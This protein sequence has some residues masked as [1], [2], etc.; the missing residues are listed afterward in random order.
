M[1]DAAPARRKHRVQGIIQL[2]LFNIP[3]QEKAVGASEPKQHAKTLW[4]WLNLLGVLAI[5]V[6]V[7][8]GVAWYT[9]QQ[10]KVSKREKTANQREI[11]LQAYIDKMSELLLE[12]GL[13]KS[14]PKD[15]VRT[16][17]R[18][19]TIT[20]LFQLDAR[21]IGYVFTFLQ[22]AGWMSSE[23]DSNIVS[24]RGADLSRANLSGADL[25]G[26]DLAMGNFKGGEPGIVN[27]SGAN[28][29]GAI[30]GVLTLDGAPNLEGITGLSPSKLLSNAMHKGSTHP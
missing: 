9:A 25:S 28:L 5:P 12:T 11:A 26:A 7:G 22:E 18:M 23:A 6:I 24:L 27:L 2:L 13:G 30:P 15:E 14:S 17:A 3:A 21:R 1:P 10:G 16:I 4:D 19:R 29:K 20:L 8:L